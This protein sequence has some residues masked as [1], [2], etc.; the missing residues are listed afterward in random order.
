[1]QRF[2]THSIPTYAIGIALLKGDWEEAV[3]L[4]LRPKPEDSSYIQEARKLWVD[5]KDAKAALAKFPRRCIAERSILTC[6]MKKDR[7]TDF[8]G[9]MQSVCYNISLNLTHRFLDI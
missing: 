9:A 8:L 3:D 2:G 1:M 7:Q 4:I 5:S 6:F